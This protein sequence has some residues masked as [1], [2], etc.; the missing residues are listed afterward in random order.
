LARIDFPSE[1]IELPGGAP[2]VLRNM[3]KQA[4]LADGAPGAADRRIVILAFAVSS[5]DSLARR[6][7]LSYALTVRTFLIENGVRAT[8]IDLRAV[9]ARKWQGYPPSNRVEILLYPVTQN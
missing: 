2:A 3:I 5:D 7:A 9:G 4:G 8:H 1:S 6:M